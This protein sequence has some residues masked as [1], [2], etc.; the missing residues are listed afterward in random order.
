MP[1]TSSIP[2]H[3][4]IIMDGNGRWAKA[5]GLPRT[6]GHRRGLDVAKSIV[7]QAE[8][9][10]IRFVSL[11]VF[12]TEN[13]KR[14]A[15]EVDFL[16]SLI[17]KHLSAEFGFYREN[18]IRILHS[19][20]RTGLPK[21]VLAEID[22]VVADTAKFDGL[23]LNMA[24][25]HGGRD[26]IVRAVRALSRAGEEVTETSI[27]KA[28]DAPE[29]PEMDLVIRTGGEKRLSNFLLW[30]SAYAELFFSGTLWPDFSDE[31]FREA[32][33]DYSGR[34]RRFGGVQ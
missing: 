7:L 25:N 12:S 15:E 30:R 28:I 21:P 24:I 18:G 34:E 16:M 3:V 32:I 19:G 6:E 9:L 4:G 10:G 1:G 27:A 20:D 2:R 33:L 29:V 8:R 14:S 13:W 31:E 17:S 23:I 5:R 11:Y 22:A 26:E